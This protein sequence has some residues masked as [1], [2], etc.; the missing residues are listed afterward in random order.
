MFVVNVDTKS[1]M[2]KVGQRDSNLDLKYQSS[3]C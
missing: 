3:A 1:R 2:G